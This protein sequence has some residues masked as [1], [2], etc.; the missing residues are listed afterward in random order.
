MIKTII[1][2]FGDVFIDLDKP[3]TLKALQQIGDF[4]LTED[5]Q[6]ANNLYETGRIDTP[7]FLNTYS[8]VLPKATNQQL[9][10]AWNAILIGFPE[11]RLNFIKQLA[12]NKKYTLILL[13]NTNKL[14][15]DWIKKNISFYQEFKQCF[16]AFYLSHE[17]HLRKPNRDI[18]NYV[19]NQHQ[20]IPSEVLFIDDTKVNTDAAK[21]LGIQVWN[22]NPE[23]DDITNLFTIKSDLF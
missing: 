17:I 8:S 12:K 10:T 21:N 20:L 14:H 22:N 15:I 11:H 19:L 16:D 13:S 23:K 9:T 7:E 1:F 3:A 2:D 4:E 6:N 18:Y 5:I